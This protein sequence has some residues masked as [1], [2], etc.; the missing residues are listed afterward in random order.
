MRQLRP[1]SE[2]ERDGSILAK[3]VDFAGDRD[4]KFCHALPYGR[5]IDSPFSDIALGY[6]T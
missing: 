6:K 4:D 3:S 5:S 1:K 2:R